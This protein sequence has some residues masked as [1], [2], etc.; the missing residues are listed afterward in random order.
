MALRTNSVSAFQ[1]RLQK[2]LCKPSW[3]LTELM[4]RQAI[5][6]INLTTAC[7]HS[8]AMI[9]SHGNGC[10]RSFFFFFFVA[11][12]KRHT[13]PLISSSRVNHTSPIVCQHLWEPWAPYDGEKRPKPAPKPEAQTLPPSPP[14]RA[15]LSAQ[16][17]TAAR[18][19]QPGGARCRAAAAT[20]RPQ[21]RA[22]PAQRALSGVCRRLRLGFRI[23]DQ[24]CYR[25]N[26]FVLK[27]QQ[28]KLMCYL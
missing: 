1:L 22:A 6:S 2:E 19:R 18:R 17:R 27:R 4:R 7:N 26:A 14:H 24:T 13:T 9:P 16:R 12:I 20:A 21:Q 8:S 10:P 25:Q 3:E 28:S 15:A 5:I 11:Q 23:S